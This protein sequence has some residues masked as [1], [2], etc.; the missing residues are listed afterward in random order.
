MCLKASWLQIIG[1]IMASAASSG[2]GAEPVPSVLKGGV[3]SFETPQPASADAWQQQKPELRKRLWR[4]LGD[5]PPLFTPK[6]AVHKREVRDGY[7]REYF[8]FD[9]GVGD[10]VY[11]YLLLPAGCERAWTGNPLQSLSWRR[12]RPGQGRT[13]CPGFCFVGKQD[14]GD[15]SRV[16]PRGLHRALY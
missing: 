14:A 13:L 5:L 9:N 10:T 3:P 6:A 16:G 7:T 2:F 15:G 4:L 12:L 1:A 11:G 8:T